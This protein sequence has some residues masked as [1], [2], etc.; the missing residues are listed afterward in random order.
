MSSP[1]DCHESIPD[2]ELLVRGIKPKYIRSGRIHKSAFMP[3]KTQPDR[4]SPD[5]EGLSV[6]LLRNEPLEKL[7]LRVFNENGSYCSLAA[8]ALH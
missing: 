2:E 8:G 4:P 6:S 1:A 7:K 3:R 5:A